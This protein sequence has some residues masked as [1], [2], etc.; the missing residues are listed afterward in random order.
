[1]SPDERNDTADPLKALWTHEQ[2]PGRIALE[3]L[4][5]EMKRRRW[6]MLVTVAGEGVLTLGLVALTVVVLGADGAASPS[7]V[8]WLGLLWLTWVIAAGFATWNR[9]GVWRPSAETARSYLALSEERARRRRRVATFVLG[10][11][12]L[13]LV[14]LLVVGEA[15]PV[16][17]ALVAA[18]VGWAVWYRRRAGRDLEAVRRITDELTAAD[19]DV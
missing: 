11:V 4:R 7:T 3:D 2:P 14:V 5:A 15:H 16:G 17:L 12:S 8:T 13:Q 10:L 19:P 1:M 18:Y 9:W 6:R